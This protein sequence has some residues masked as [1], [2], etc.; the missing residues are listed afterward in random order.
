MTGQIAGPKRGEREL[1]D[2]RGRQPRRGQTAVSWSDQA[3]LGSKN[4]DP[5]GGGG[6]GSADDGSEAKS[7]D[8]GDQ[9]SDD[10]GNGKSKG[11]DKKDKGKGKGNDEGQDDENV[12][13]EGGDADEDGETPVSN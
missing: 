10:G 9:G 3:A 2:R 8:G 12:D 4:Y 7:D 11:K 6:E 1:A 5:P 13:D